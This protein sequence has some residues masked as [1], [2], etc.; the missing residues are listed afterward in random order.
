MLYRQQQHNDDTERSLE[1]TESNLHI[2]LDGAYSA[3]G[4]SLFNLTDPTLSNPS[5]ADLN[6]SREG[7]T[8]TFSLASMPLQPSKTAWTPGHVPHKV[9]N[10]QL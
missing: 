4:S 2:G 5:D 1:E 10:F 3:F 7:E 9:G 6:L 8:S